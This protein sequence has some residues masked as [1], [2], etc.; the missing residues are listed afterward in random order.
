MTMRTRT[1]YACECGHTGHSVLSE[2]DQPYSQ[3]WERFDAFGFSEA[4]LKR[5]VAE[6]KC[7]AC[8]QTGSVR[9]A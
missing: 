2:N 4:D 5:P 7:P 1:D 8:G 9:I 6:I 3:M